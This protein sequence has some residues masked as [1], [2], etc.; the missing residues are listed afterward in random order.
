VA[1]NGFRIFCT[2]LVVQSGHPDLAEGFLHGFA[3]WLIFVAALIMFFAVHRLISLIWK[4][5]PIS[6]PILAPVEEQRIAESHPASNSLFGIVAVLMLATAIGLQAHSTTEIVPPHLSLSSLPS[7]IDGWTGTDLPIGPDA[8]KTL[9]YPE[10]LLRDYVNPTEPQ[11]SI[12]LYMVYYASQKAGDKIHSPQHC[13]P[14]AGWIPTSRSVVQLV[15]PDGST[16]PVNRY[17]V[18]KSFDRQLVLYWFQAHGR[19][20]ASEWKAEYYLISDSIHMNR[21]DGGMV[22]LMTPMRDGE[23]ADEAQA[24]MMK[25]GSQFLPMIDSYI[26]R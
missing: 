14:G 1:A 21:S 4:S 6:A 25:L 15:R 24:R 9:G 23:S 22:R 26:P 8:L 19:V 20:V 10:Y 11:P 17:V 13:L 2:G 12:N 7:Q 3:G 16:M 5:R 18:S